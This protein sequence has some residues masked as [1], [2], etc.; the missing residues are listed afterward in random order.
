MYYLSI[1]LRACTSTHLTLK[2]L[3]TT[4]SFFNLIFSQISDCHSHEHL[5]ATDSRVQVNYSVTFKVM[6]EAYVSS[7]K[8][9]LRFFIWLPM[10]VH[11]HINIFI[12]IY[13]YMYIHRPARCCAGKPHT[14]D[15]KRRTSELA[16]V[17][18]ASRLVRPRLP[19]GRS[20]VRDP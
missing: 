19:R 15:H 6:V 4:L 5:K 13:T 2:L 17:V 14:P 10:L 11:T 7:E 1:L 20:G 16:S 9:G 12:L 18:I 3:S 8:K